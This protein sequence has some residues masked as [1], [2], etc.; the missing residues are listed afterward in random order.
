MA[1]QAVLVSHNVAIKEAI[2]GA[3]GGGW[4]HTGRRKY[5]ITCTV[6]ETEIKMEVVM[7]QTIT[8]CRLE[9]HISAASAETAGK[10]YTH[11]G[12]E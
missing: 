12:S 2:C 8:C 4:D 1:G 11:T 10:S 9:H 3:A 6:R 5:T 7:L